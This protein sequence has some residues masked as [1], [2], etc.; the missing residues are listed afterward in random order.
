MDQRSGGMERPG[1]ESAESGREKLP[2]EAMLA[3]Q[4]GRKIEAIRIAR[5]QTGMSLVEAKR[6]VERAARENEPAI[7]RRAGEEDSGILRLVAIIVVL[8][9]LAAAMF[10]L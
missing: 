5:E 7:P 6:L 10:L 1:L 9:A 8:G 2:T 4:S 3:L